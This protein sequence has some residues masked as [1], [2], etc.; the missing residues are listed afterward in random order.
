MTIWNRK[1]LGEIDINIL[2]EQI[3]SYMDQTAESQTVT[4]L[5]NKFNVSRYKIYQIIN[6]LEECGKVKGLGSTR[7]KKYIINR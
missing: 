2:K 6:E 3:L 7:G 4:N 5:M 1:I